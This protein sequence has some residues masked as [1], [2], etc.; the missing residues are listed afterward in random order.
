MLHGTEKCLSVSHI[1]L[2]LVPHSDA[3]RTTTER[4]IDSNFFITL[5]NN[6]WNK[7]WAN[8]L[9]CGRASYPP[10]TRNNHKR[11]SKQGRFNS[12]KSV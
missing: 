2:A 12:D 1:T 4:N 11:A 10:G 5:A 6:S 7:D 8:A 9:G 3:S